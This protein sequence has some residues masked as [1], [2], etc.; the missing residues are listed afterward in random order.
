MNEIYLEGRGAMGGRGGCTRVFVLTLCSFAKEKR[1]KHTNR[2][3]KKNRPDIKKHRLLPWRGQER[4]GM[5][6]GGERGGVYSVRVRSEGGV[7]GG[8]WGDDDARLNK[9][10]SKGNVFKCG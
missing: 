8:G 9:L 1:K 4:P 2:Q 7:M 5:E 3:T 10:Q 6:A